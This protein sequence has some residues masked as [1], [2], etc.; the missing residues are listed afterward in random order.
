[1]LSINS[2][3]NVKQAD[4]NYAPVLTHFLDPRGQYILEVI[5]RSYQ[6]LHVTFL[7]DHMQKEN[8]QSSHHYILSHSLRTLN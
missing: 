4:A 6:D 1:M 7:V 3:I 5:T 8:V 2:S